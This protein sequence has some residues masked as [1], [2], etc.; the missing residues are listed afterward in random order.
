MPK[1][2]LKSTLVKYSTALKQ[3]KIKRR[4]SVEKTPMLKKNVAQNFEYS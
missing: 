1:G 3:K 2:N 4:N